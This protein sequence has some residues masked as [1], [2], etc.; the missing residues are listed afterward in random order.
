MSYKAYMKV[1]R[2]RWALDKGAGMIEINL[3]DSLVRE[4]TNLFKDYEL[5]AKSGLQQNVRVFAQHL[6]QPQEFEVNV[7]Y[8][9]DGINDEDTTEPIGYTEADIE[10]YFPCIIV[11]LDGTETKEEGTTD[12]YKI[13]VKI[14]VGIYDD[15]KDLQGYRDVLDILEKIRQY[16]LSMPNRILE[17][18]YQLLMPLNTDLDSELTYPFYFGQLDTIFETARPLMSY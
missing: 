16:L 15:A 17:G 4:I 9:E 13:K 18:R 5:K 8:D 3:L 6:P 2:G 10:A 11:A 12:A 1:S 14:L 7:N